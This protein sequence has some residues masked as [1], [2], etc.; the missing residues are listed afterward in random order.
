MKKKEIKF[1]LALYVIKHRGHRLL[2]FE[3]ND[4][5]VMRNLLLTTT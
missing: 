1:N 5:I 2:E 4:I 3:K